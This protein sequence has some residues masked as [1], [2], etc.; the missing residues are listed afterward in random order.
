[1]ARTRAAQEND[2]Q[3]VAEM[4]SE[5]GYPTAPVVA[6]RRLR[7]TLADPAACVVVADDGPLV[8]GLLA[9]RA[10]PYFPS[11][12]QVFRVTALVVAAPHRGKGIG[13][14]LLEHGIQLAAK[15]GCTGVELTSAE[16]RAAAHAFYER[17][18][19]TRTSAR[20]FRTVDR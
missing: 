1:M 17:L 2:A 20:Y 5:L 13:R 7:E 16:H 4:L 12:A 11:G 6:E 18:G 19:F 9:G 15:R 8:V 10:A 3:G 14:A